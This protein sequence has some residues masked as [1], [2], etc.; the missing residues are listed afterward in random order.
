MLNKTKNIIWHNENTEYSNIY[1]IW[2][3]KK[4]KEIEN[5]WKRK[6]IVANKRWWNECE[7]MPVIQLHINEWR[8]TREKR[9][10]TLEKGIQNKTETKS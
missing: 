2:K 3:Q 1:V 10:I 8:R 9:H 6:N 7:K 5:K 4:Q